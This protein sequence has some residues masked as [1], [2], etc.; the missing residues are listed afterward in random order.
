ME[1]QHYIE[2]NGIRLHYVAMGTG[3]TILFLH[4][5]PEFWYAWK[6]QLHAFRKDYQVV[7]LDLR[8]YNLS[9]KPAPPEAY[10]LVYLLDDVRAL[11]DHIN[12]RGKDILVGHDWGGVVAWAFALEY[13]QYLNKLII[14]N[15]PHPAIFARELATNRAQ[16]RA[17]YY[18]G[19]LRRPQAEAVLQADNYAV[20]AT[21]VFGSTVRPEMFTEEDRVIYRAAWGQPGALTGALNYYRAAGN[22]SL[23]STA[24]ISR[25]ADSTSAF[26]VHVPTLV[27]WGE[28]DTTLL[29]GN[30]VG[31][32]K[33]VPDLRIRRVAQA[34]HWIVHEEPDLV[35][36][37]IDEFIHAD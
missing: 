2:S 1:N 7:A 15:A 16:Q 36:H 14:I 28:R 4:G 9:D 34:T 27:I 12:P 18:I 19:R 29:S 32:E 22:E 13:P 26:T 31:L 25:S 5:F 30:L 10:R 35:N 11:L 6:N 37:Y 20:L 23:I 8:G 24:A 3:P 33:F 17:S 21:I